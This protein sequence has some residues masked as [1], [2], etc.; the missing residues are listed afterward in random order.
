MKL[1]I[2]REI[3]VQ[4]VA[5]LCSI[6]P[7]KPALPILSNILVEARGGEITLSATDLMVSMKIQGSAHIHEEGCATIP[8]K[9]FFSLMRELTTDRIEISHESDEITIRSGAS[10]FKLHGMPAT[11]FPAISTFYEVDSFTLPSI[12][13][14]EALHR[15]SFAAAR[16]D[17]RNVLN[18]IFF[19][20]NKDLLTL[21][22]T[23]GKRLAKLT[24]PVNMAISEVYDFVIPLKGIEEIEKI[25][26]G[27][28]EVRIFFLQDKIILQ[29]DHITLFI[30]L[31]SEKFPDVDKIIPDPKQMTSMVLHRE[32]LISL[33]RQVSLF[34]SEMVSSVRFIFE[35]NELYLFA[36]NAEIGEGRVSMPV[37]YTGEK[38]EIAF[39][40][41]Y[42]L[43]I[44]RHCKDE[45][46]ELHI[47]DP[48]N[49]GLITDSTSALFVIMPMRIPAS[50]P[51][52]S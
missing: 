33:L 17:S 40:P 6:V 16:D 2:G 20:L 28:K 37:S 24:V 43:D 49:P 52:V 44:L 23:D 7:A 3:I 46:I 1:T 47:T 18:G 5:K 31:L 50:M 21:I 12:L 45:T 19:R 4:L 10:Y 29:L 51:H 15:V 48:F 9:R 36:V 38:L 13:L 35:N 11:D 22:G 26:D 42:F 8:A 39:H 25:L 34:T 30:K 27:N 41:T 14:K 32:E